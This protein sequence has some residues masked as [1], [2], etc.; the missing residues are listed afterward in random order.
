M[1]ALGNRNEAGELLRDGLVDLC[2]ATGSVSLPDGT[3]VDISA[4][5]PVLASW[6]LRD[7]R[8]SRGTHVFREFLRLGDGG[9]RLPSSF[10]YVTPF[11]ANDPLQTPS[12]LDP[13]DN[14][15]ALEA[16]AT[17]V[18]A[19]DD[20][21]IALDEALGNIQGVTRQGE[22]IPLHGGPEHVGVLNKIEA[23]FEGAD[24][25]PEVTSA[26]SSWIQATSFDANGPVSKGIL[27]YSQS[28]N[29]ASPHYADITKKYSNKEWVDLPF[30][31]DDVEAAALSSMTLKEGRSDCKSGGW[32]AFTNPS[33]AN[34][35][36][37]VEYYDALREQRLEEIKARE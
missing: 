27:T 19:L 16:L 9:R 3:A 29:P 6:D 21:G 37:C 8:D 28:T 26:S 12:G 31:Q 23:R 1:I 35:G 11:D 14:D 5:C 4:A 36:A 32:Q 17:A 34:Q 30:H 2:E 15:A 25:Y 20:A 22:F 24:G 33:F 7:N 10:N 13:N 18:K